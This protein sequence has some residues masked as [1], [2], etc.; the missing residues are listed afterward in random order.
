MTRRARSAHD[1]DA[2]GKRFLAAATVGA[3][4]TACARRP[5]GRRGRLGTAMFFPGWITSE[6]PLHTIFWQALASA[7]W[8]RRGALRTPAGWLGLGLTGA[9]WFSL[10]KIWKQS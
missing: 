10:L 2:T 6:L 7:G 1:R 4:N 3:L 8:I 9:S 5:F